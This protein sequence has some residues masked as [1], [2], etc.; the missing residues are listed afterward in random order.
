MINKRSIDLEAASAIGN[1]VK[2]SLKRGKAPAKNKGRQFGAPTKTTKPKA[3]VNKTETSKPV[4][5]SAPK[6]GAISERKPR[7]TQPSLPG[8]SIGKIKKLDEK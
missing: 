5:E 3:S 7:Y 8:M 4:T 1:I 2:G 6:P